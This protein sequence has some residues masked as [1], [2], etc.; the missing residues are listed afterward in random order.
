MWRRI[1]SFIGW[2]WAGFCFLAALGMITN[3][4]LIAAIGALIW[5]LIFL[6]PLY[7]FTSNFN[8]GWNIGGR[9]LAF[10]LVPLIFPT[11]SQQQLNQAPVQTTS[12]VKTAPS[13]ITNEKSPKFTPT[14]EPAPKLEPTT[15]IVEPDIAPTPQIIET[16]QPEPVTT[17]EP[18]VIEPDIP[19]PVQNTPEPAAP[20]QPNL[21][22]P[23]R[24][25]VSGSCDCPYDTDK[26]GRSCGKRSAYSRP[27]G[28]NPVCYIRD[29]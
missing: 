25:G 13:T 16:S 11:S 3:G 24:A 18:K 1:L 7:R 8:R 9:I 26:R 5:G 20:P 2:L 23:V 21:N 10:I 4:E 14:A 29:Q 28:G 27:N 19:K 17:P 12:P 6:P 22:S 15:K